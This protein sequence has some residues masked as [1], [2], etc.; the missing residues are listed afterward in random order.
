M[1]SANRGRG[2]WIIFSEA[3][4]Q[5]KN[6]VKKCIGLLFKRGGLVFRFLQLVRALLVWNLKIFCERTIGFSS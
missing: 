4:F 3:H 5:N 2:P 1:H 6:K